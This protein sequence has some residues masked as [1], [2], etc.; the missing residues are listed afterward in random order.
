MTIKSLLLSR[1]RSAITIERTVSVF[2]VI[3]TASEEL[4]CDVRLRIESGWVC[5]LLRRAEDGGEYASFR[6]IPYAEQPL[7][8]LRFKE[9]QPARPW[10]HLLDATEEGPVCPQHDEIYEHLIDPHRGM[11]EACI[12]A[13]IHIPLAALSLAQ[14]RDNSSNYSE[15]GQQGVKKGFPI[16]VFIHGGG[17][18]AGLSDTDLHG[19]EYLVNKGIILITFNYRINVFGFLSLNNPKIPG[20]NGL[21]DQVTLLRWVQ[22]NAE[23]FGGDPD[24]VTLGGQ[25][26]GAACAH[27]LSLSNAAKGLFKRV[28]LMS[29]TAIPSF[30]TSSPIYANLIASAFLAYLGINA[31]SPDDIHD[32]LI[33]TPLEDILRANTRIQYDF[34]L[35][36]FTP[37]VEP[38]YQ[39]VTR[40][41][42]DTPTNLMIQG[43]GNELPFLVG[44]ADQECEFFRRR[45]EYLK[46]LSR[47]KINPLLVLPARIPFSTLPNVAL[48]LAEKVIKR[49]FHEKPSI[50]DVLQVCRDS[51]FEYP[52][53]KLGQ[54]RDEMKAASFY[55]Y[56]FSYESDY[57]V[58]KAGLRLQY[59]GTAHVEDQTF[60]LKDNTILSGEKSLP[61]S[62][63]DDLMQKLMTTF[64]VNFM[65][66]N[67]PTCGSESG[68]HHLH[69]QN[70]NY[71][72][73]NDPVLLQNTVP[74]H[75]QKDMI[76]FFD[77][78]EDIAR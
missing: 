33:K 36:S 49:Y 16:L 12:Y 53:F 45:L 56:Q 66:C 4:K 17:F 71:L 3:V 21:R 29:G 20:N 23:A 28:I 5:G 18:Q 27:I 8:Q 63:R 64:V 31:T 41:L 55:L 34:G 35:V 59:K 19:P 42:D 65:R 7:G 25:S 26:A 14:T 15:H 39:G 58:V 10:P 75:D 67:D 43:R 72:D 73:I 61:R 70:L 74:R 9:L 76:Q 52:S 24:D 78:I 54:L 44:F 37:V 6:G 30:F 32:A 11:S 51:F 1:L 40:I 48:Q 57:S 38:P 62:D 2:K 46:F 47:I 50:K 68:W 22:R 77:G 13:N 69:A 60:V